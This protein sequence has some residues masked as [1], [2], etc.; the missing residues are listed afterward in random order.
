MRP[1]YHPPA[2]AITVEGILYALSNPVRV[3]IYAEIASADCPRICASFLKID[4]KPLAKS[5]LS[6]H[7]KVLR[8]SGL[9]R[10][11][12]KGT[13]LHNTTR[14]KEL[15]ERFGPLVSS[16]LEAYG[17]QSERVKKHLAP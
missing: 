16:I 12:R 8:E 3:R 17:S 9:I 11:E 7:F 1:L 14:C 15:S 13:E 4:N 6:Q 10:S 2:S 5:T